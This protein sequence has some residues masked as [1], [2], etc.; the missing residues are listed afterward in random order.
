MSSTISIKGIL[1]FLKS[2]LNINTAHFAWDILGGKDAIKEVAKEKASE[3]AN[4]ILAD[5]FS[6]QQENLFAEK[7]ALLTFDQRMFVAELL[8]YLGKAENGRKRTQLLKLRMIGVSVIVDERLE[9]IFGK[10]QKKIKEIL[11]KVDPRNTEKDPVLKRLQGLCEDFKNFKERNAALANDEL[12]SRF[13]K[14]LS[15][16]ELLNEKSYGEIVTEEVMN[17]LKYLEKVDKPLSETTLRFALGD[18]V[19][20]AFINRHGSYEAARPYLMSRARTQYNKKTLE[21]EYRNARSFSK[22]ISMIFKITAIVIGLIF[23]ILAIN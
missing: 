17:V 5:K 3:I 22:K 15:A 20:N 13:I 11:H 21:V 4:S 10:D 16:H 12:Y 19:V 23:L 7:V 2:L 8:D 9:T 18:K 6:Q 14:Y 1:S